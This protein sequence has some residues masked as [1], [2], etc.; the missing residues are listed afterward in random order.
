M[1]E[2]AAQ[3]RVKEI[4]TSEADRML[5]AREAAEAQAFDELQDAAAMDL[6]KQ[7]QA[8][9]TAAK[10][11]ESTRASED[12]KRR[13]KRVRAARAKENQRRR[14]AEARRCAQLVSGRRKQQTEVDISDAAKVAL[15]PQKY[16]PQIFQSEKNINKLGITV[17]RR[18][19]NSRFGQYEK[20]KQLG[21]LTPGILND[22]SARETR[23]E[24]LRAEIRKLEE[25]S[26][27]LGESTQAVGGTAMVGAMSLRSTSPIMMVPYGGSVA[28]PK[29]YSPP[30][31]KKKKSP[32]GPGISIN[33]KR[34]QLAFQASRANGRSTLLKIMPVT[35]R[36]F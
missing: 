26:G 9:A 20:A 24:M 27:N 12:A 2:S 13:A 17:E 11:R 16:A 34:R 5:R 4:R 10:E 6:E 14:D 28:S 19:Y 36:N 15:D 3:K 29:L 22:K 32:R 33:Q 31:P 1:E 35:M 8:S 25:V 18:T 23:A 30:K 7:K 21:P